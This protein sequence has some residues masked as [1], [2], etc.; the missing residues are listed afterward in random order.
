MTE[1]TGNSQLAAVMEEAA[2][3]RKGLAQRIRSLSE[4]H[5]DDPPASPDHNR[6]RRWVVNGEVPK[7]S[8]QQYIVQALAAKLGRKLSLAE[9]GFP[10]EVPDSD[11]P[12]VDGMQYPESVG[13]SIQVLSG[14]TEADQQGKDIR[15]GQS[16]ENVSSIITRHL[17]AQQL[18]VVTGVPAEGKRGLAAPIR[19]TT[20]RSCSSTFS[21][22]AVTFGA[23]C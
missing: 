11:E 12:T 2:V 15:L 1:T 8:T 23:C 10:E 13:Q 6:V 3:S 17:L 20:A 5:G 19:D 18:T 4:R 14:V 16:T 21:T 9:V 7:L 22:G